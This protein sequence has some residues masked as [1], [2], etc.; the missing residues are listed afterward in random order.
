MKAIVESECFVK[1]NAGYYPKKD[2]PLLGGWK[3]WQNVGGQQ[4]LARNMMD[5]YII[6]N[7]YT[8]NECLHTNEHI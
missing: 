3:L 4:T 6:M 2:C 1:S 5:G 8:G 7:V